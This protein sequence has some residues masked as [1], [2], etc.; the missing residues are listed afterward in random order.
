MEDI[1]NKSKELHKRLD[2]LNKK[3]DYSLFEIKKVNTI[4]K[5]ISY[6]YNASEKQQE[7]FAGNPIKLVKAKHY[8]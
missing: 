4:F 2:E 3:M 5:Q 7:T 8:R 1:T 6:S